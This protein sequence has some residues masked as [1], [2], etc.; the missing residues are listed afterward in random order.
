M[1]AP[2]IIMADDLN[3]SLN[4]VMAG[5]LMQ[6]ATEAAAA[7]CL[8]SCTSVKGERGL[9]AAFTQDHRHKVM[10]VPEHTQE[11]IITTTG[12]FLFFFTLGCGR[13]SKDGRYANDDADKKVFILSRVPIM[14]LASFVTA[15]PNRPDD[16]SP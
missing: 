6:F 7:A 5:Y 4:D 9:S 1:D 3:C 2:R 10:R 16:P 8:R 11:K 12:N 14:T 15:M 13:S